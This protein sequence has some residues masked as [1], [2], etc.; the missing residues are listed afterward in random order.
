MENNDNNENGGNKVVQHLNSI[1]FKIDSLLE[2]QQFYV[3][4][5]LNDT[6]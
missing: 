6:L 5:L 2:K 1:I 3:I 4:Q